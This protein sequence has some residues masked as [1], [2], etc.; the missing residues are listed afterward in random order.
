VLI[1]ITVLSR[2]MF[3]GDSTSTRIVDFLITVTD[4]RGVP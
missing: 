3:F 2:S 1:N 4:G